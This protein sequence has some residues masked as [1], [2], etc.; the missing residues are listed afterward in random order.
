MVKEKDDQVSHLKYQ[1]AL[2]SCLSFFSP[3]FCR[4]I[5]TFTQMQISARGRLQML[6]ICCVLQYFVHL[7]S[8]DFQRWRHPTTLVFI[9]T[10]RILQFA[11]SLADGFSFVIPGMV[12]L[13]WILWIFGHVVR[14]LP[15]GH[16]SYLECLDLKGSQNLSIPVKLKS[17]HQVFHLW[18]IVAV[19]S[20]TLKN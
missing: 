6:E 13:Y 15:V 16:V 14:G 3:G 9:P 11:S 17:H 10:E 18:V 20:T 8:G 2:Y 19:T 12:D 1:F 4:C 7:A 5:A